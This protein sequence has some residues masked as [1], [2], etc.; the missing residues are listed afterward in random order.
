[1]ATKIRKKKV[2]N[3][4]SFDELCALRDSLHDYYRRYFNVIPSSDRA[5]LVSAILSVMDS[6]DKF[7]SV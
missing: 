2:L 5:S 3:P 6:I 4:M 1:M 7:K